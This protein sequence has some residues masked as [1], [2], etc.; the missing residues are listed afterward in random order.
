MSTYA[1]TSEAPTAAPAS[2]RDAPKRPRKAPQGIG[3]GHAEQTAALS[4][5]PLPQADDNPALMRAKRA[6]R[7][8]Q[9][10]SGTV[11]R[12]EALLAKDCIG[13]VTDGDAVEALSL[14]DGMML[15]TR[16]T[17]M[18]SLKSGSIE[19]LADEL[20]DDEAHPY[21]S[22][23]PAATIALAV[24][25]SRTEP[26]HWYMRQNPA[27]VGLTLHHG[28]EA[29]LLL[30]TMTDA[31]LSLYAQSRPLNFDAW[32][33]QAPAQH[34]CRKRMQTVARES[35]AA[36]GKAN[37]E[38][39]RRDAAKA[40]ADTHVAANK[41]LVTAC[42]SLKDLLSYAAFDW[43]ITDAEARKALGILA[44]IDN[45]ADREA[46]I[47]DL[48][49]KGLNLDRLADNLSEEDRQLS[50]P[51][52]LSVMS[53]REPARNVAMLED[54]LSGDCL[55]DMSEA[56]A[57]LVMQMMHALPV[58]EQTRLR[59]MQDGE[60]WKEMTS[61]L[62]IEATRDQTTG[63]AGQSEDREPLKAM[64][65]KHAAKWSQERVGAVARMLRAM[66]EGD[67]VSRTASDL[68]VAIPQPRQIEAQDAGTM[69]G[70]GLSLLAD[71]ALTENKGTLDLDDILAATGLA[72]EFQLAKL[73]GD[74]PQSEG[75][76]ELHFT[77]S[78][79]QLVAHIPT[80]VLAG[81]YKLSGTTKLE[82]GPLVAQG[83]TLDLKWPSDTSPDAWFKLSLGSL[84]TDHLMQTTPQGALNLGK[85]SLENFELEAKQ[86]KSANRP[87][88]EDRISYAMSVLQ[89][90]MPGFTALIEAASNAASDPAAMGNAIGGAFPTMTNANI[91]LGALSVDGVDTSDGGHID[92][93]AM[94]GLAVMVRNRLKDELLREQIEDVESR[95][96]GP[97]TNDFM[98]RKLG[99]QLVQLELQWRRASEMRARLDVLQAKDD[100]AMVAAE[101]AEMHALRKALTVQTTRAGFNELAVSGV[102]AGGIKAEL[103]AISGLRVTATTY[104][105]AA[106]NSQIQASME[107]SVQAT[108]IVKGGDKTRYQQRL[109]ALK[110]LRAKTDKTP[111]E[112]VRLEDIEASFGQ[113]IT[114]WNER[115][116]LRMEAAAASD[117]ETLSPETQA[118]LQTLDNK[119]AVWDQSC[120]DL[121]VGQLQGRLVADIANGEASA[122]IIG[123]VAS[124]IHV[125]E[126][127][128]KRVSA[129]QLGVAANGIGGA[130]SS[131][132]MN[133]RGLHAEGLETGV[134]GQEGYKAAA[135]AHL[136][137]LDADYDSE[138]LGGRVQAQLKGLKLEDIEH[139]TAS[140]AQALDRKVRIL[141]K[142]QER[143]EE[144]EGEGESE[145]QTE[146]RRK[147]ATKLKR[148]LRQQ[149]RYKKLKI[150][151]VKA[152][153]RQGRRWW[154]KKLAKWHAATVLTIKEVTAEDA[155][156]T[157]ING[158]PD[159]A[160][161][162]PNFVG[163]RTRGRVKA[164]GIKRNGLSVEEASA[165]QV[166]GGFS[167]DG[168][169]QYSL[170]AEELGVTNAR[171]K[172]N[173]RLRAG[174]LNKATI[175]GANEGP[176]RVEAGKFFGKGLRG[177]GVAAGGFGGSN[178]RAQIGE[179]GTISGDAQHTWLRDGRLHGSTK[180]RVRDG[181]ASGVKFRM[182]ANSNSFSARRLKAA[183]L[184][185]SQGKGTKPGLQVGADTLASEH[186]SFSQQK[187]GSEGIKANLGETTLSGVVGNVPDKDGLGT[188]FA[189]GEVAFEKLAYKAHQDRATKT[190]H[191]TLGVKGLDVSDGM[192][193]GDWGQAGAD[194]ITAGNL[195]QTAV[196]PKGQAGTSTY[197]VQNAAVL[198]GSG[199]MG[200]PDGQTLALG[201][202]LTT[203]G[204]ANVTQTPTEVSATASGVQTDASGLLTDR[205]GMPQRRFTSDLKG[206]LSYIKKGD[207]EI[208]KGSLKGHVN[209]DGDPVNP[210]MKLP[211]GD[212][213]HGGGGNI[214]LQDVA[215]TQNNKTGERKLTYGH[216][217]GKN[218]HIT[219]FDGSKQA[220]LKS[221]SLGRKGKL[222]NIAI[223]ADGIINGD[224]YEL[225][226]VT[227][228]GL[229]LP[230]D[231]LNKLKLDAG[232]KIGHVQLRKVNPADLAAAGSV[233][234]LDD[235][236]VF[237]SE[238]GINGTRGYIDQFGIGELV[239]KGLGDGKMQ[240][241]GDWARLRGRLA[242][243]VR[244]DV[245]TDLEDFGATL[246]VGD[247]VEVLSGWLKRAKSD[248]EIEVDLGG[249]SGANPRSSR[250]IMDALRRADGQVFIQEAGE[251]EARAPLNAGV[252]D[253]TQAKGWIKL[254]GVLA[255]L[256]SGLVKAG[257]QVW[258]NYL[259]TYDIPKLLTEPGKQG[260]DSS[261]KIDELNVSL[262][263]QK[264]KG[265]LGVE[266]D[267]RATTFNIDSFQRLGIGK[268]AHEGVTMSAEALV[269]KNAHHETL[270]HILSAGKG[271]LPT[272]ELRLIGPTATPTSIKI[273]IGN[274]TV[275]NV[276]LQRKE[277][278]AL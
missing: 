153:T 255:P 46:V 79:D 143:L 176:T 177:N 267:E 36:T 111:E 131:A 208:F 145:A 109:A 39:H 51:A 137:A 80:L 104:Q 199:Q 70:G 62:S 172:G 169:G 190:K 151:A 191:S 16:L 122:A 5:A 119:L 139:Q 38:A 92:G 94:N 195:A 265:R 171:D 73:P 149:R 49:A 157:A 253:A 48:E 120:P 136:D 68:G 150:R 59:T 135:S 88:D 9:E 44:G 181:A 163:V 118:R 257:D 19:R 194:R 201:T 99:G 82:S 182:G 170:S 23:H 74:G 125:G 128:A 228:K 4:P 8:V 116:Q 270:T 69:V 222:S 154:R 27:D 105:D 231:V 65:A 124:D 212:R 196:T 248:L 230:L 140:M 11:A 85:C 203:I 217:K 2:R 197:A 276:K 63:F 223:G 96:A 189:G 161:F 206:G 262:V 272:M 90:L 224:L 71:G 127:K 271:R 238:I 168:T 67:F 100:A 250:L 273:N 91:T 58:A 41:D 144:S 142:T 107:A 187:W 269:I 117:K 209:Y 214:D 243:D 242:G 158:G 155:S 25:L 72:E 186:A 84:M 6:A 77:R 60:F 115:E 30:D 200:L 179:G 106:G 7:A 193:F 101:R 229:E 173:Y 1:P 130:I 244:G 232:A 75:V 112:E 86:P 234:R 52:F 210:L 259:K 219:K 22:Q 240:I 266:S 89:D 87:E 97:R 216:I 188:H 245:A 123:A 129:D 218:L 93:V 247:S 204:S 20:P 64:F 165:D 174:R 166:S 246:K 260:S 148:A 263:F 211:N 256:D 14:L 108:G 3:I 81:V 167:M 54:L 274:S 37:A 32:T 33:Q 102:D 138:L 261:D 183:G 207:E 220:I 55:G 164:K 133:V 264:L 233:I 268:R 15:P 275:N 47:L 18:A 34:P 66:G 156:I 249:D 237:D 221:L 278:P 43:T 95:M 205:Y 76:N 178:L 184:D 180:A 40:N 254:G 235:V 227:A 202:G 225:R 162:D 251:L 10:Q 159:L 26:L 31:E 146:Q 252:I 83:I 213:I 110:A 160:N 215:Y 132:S 192:A 45:V 35:A 134:K 56:D 103:A 185:V 29:A 24:H 121:K 42:E 78:D 28:P 50:L 12:I 258:D 113:T 226:I 175:A 57:R 98:R 61:E 147:V 13:N 21:R 53:L 152:K 236:R 17:V 114:L 241:S 126:T 141:L 277:T 198:N 239:Q